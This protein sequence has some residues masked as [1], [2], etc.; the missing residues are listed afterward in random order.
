MKP[1][2][3]NVID[4]LKQIPKGTVMTYGQVA[5]MAGSPRGARQVVRVLHTMSRKHRLPWHRVVNRNGQIV[6][7]DDEGA[8][9]QKWLLEDEGVKVSETGRVDLDVYGFR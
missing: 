3:A 2:T 6:L 7:K 8:M 9:N 5:K 1:F 4:I